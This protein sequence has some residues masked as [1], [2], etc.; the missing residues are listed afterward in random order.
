MRDKL[1][2]Y[3]QCNFCDK[4]LSAS[5][6]ARTTAEHIQSSVVSSTFNCQLQLVGSYKSC[7][8]SVC[9]LLTTGSLIT[10]TNL[11]ECC[12][13]VSVPSSLSVIGQC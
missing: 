13:G 7:I 3:I 12:H 8:W 10:H 11:L 5:N 6:S 2:V 4:H 9:P 1:E